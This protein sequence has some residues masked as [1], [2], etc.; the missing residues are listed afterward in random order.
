[1]TYLLTHNTEPPG[2]PVI[3]TVVALNSSS[4]S[5]SWTPP[6]YNC[7]LNHI[8]EVVNNV[9]NL[10]A[11]SDITTSTGLIVAPLMVGESYIFRVAS[12]DAAERMSDQSQPVSLAMKG[13]A[14]L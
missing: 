3:N 6:P 11:F 14:M 1:M 8:V 9:C 12:V 10:V 5:L 2:P 4:A 7:S 13:L